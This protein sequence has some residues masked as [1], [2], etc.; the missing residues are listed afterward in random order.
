MPVNYRTEVKKT[1]IESLDVEAYS[2]IIYD[3]ADNVLYQ[4]FA[5]SF[6]LADMMLKDEIERCGYPCEHCAC[7]SSN[8]DRRCGCVCHVEP[9]AGVRRY[10]GVSLAV[11]VSEAEAVRFNS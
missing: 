1:I 4:G 9:D 6:E 3:D 8:Y 2:A 10:Y 7:D 5:T 11:D